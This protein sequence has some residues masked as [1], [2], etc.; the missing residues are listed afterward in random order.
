MASSRIS[1]D[2]P[3]E[4]CRLKIDEM[5]PLL[6]EYR[7]GKK[8]RSDSSTDSATTAK[9]AKPSYS[10]L[11]DF[12]DT[13]SKPTR[14]RSLSPAKRKID[15]SIEVSRAKRSKSDPVECC[16]RTPVV[17]LRPLY[18][19]LQSDKDDEDID[20]STS[21]SSVF[22][23]DANMELLILEKTSENLKSLLANWKEANKV[24][25]ELAKSSDKMGQLVE[26]FLATTK[27]KNASEVATP[28]I[29]EQAKTPA[30]TPC[31]KDIASELVRRMKSGF[32]DAEVL[33]PDLE[34]KYNANLF[35]LMKITEGLDA[36][37]YN[38]TPT[39]WIVVP[40]LRTE[41][42]NAYYALKAH[43]YIAQK[44]ASS[45]TAMQRHLKQ[46]VIDFFDRCFTYQVAV[47]HR[48]HVLLTGPL[49]RVGGD[50]LFRSSDGLDTGG[51]NYRELDNYNQEVWQ[52]LVIQ[53]AEMS[54]QNSRADTPL[55]RNRGESSISSLGLTRLFLDEEEMDYEGDDEASFAAE[56][57]SAQDEDPRRD[58]GIDVDFAP[59]DISS[60]GESCGLF[61]DPYEEQD[62]EQGD[63]DRQL[64]TG[65]QSLPAKEHE[66]KL[67]PERLSGF[68]GYQRV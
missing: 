20:D 51:E 44:T 15:E 9:D 67:V 64:M 55:R 30:L 16:P 39:I 25:A 18:T 13:E 60:E 11:V 36:L 33:N 6:A 63:G 27:R 19:S 66:M 10:D 1:R 34:K 38:V 53:S 45:S 59:P 21:T 61:C 57:A 22:N 14:T 12:L 31:S 54:T 7:E 8:S 58:S 48:V 2:S 5:E 29:P 42:E 46:D 26:H 52:D 24:L 32:G 3:V 35:Y 40:A 68:E 23:D 62:S 49:L 43:P 4:S 17:G 65:S 47:V 56:R 50:A 28:K 41:R 37:P